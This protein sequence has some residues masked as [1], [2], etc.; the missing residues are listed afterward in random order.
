MIGVRR[1]AVATPPVLDGDGSAGRKERAAAVRFYQVPANRPK[2]FPAG[3][4]VYKSEE[5][6]EALTVLFHG[7][8]AY[9]E[10]R[11][12][13]VHPV[14]IEHYR[15][16]AA[17]EHRGALRK[18]GYYWLAAEWTNL[19][20]S[21]IDCNRSRRHPKLGDDADPEISGKAN[22]FPI[23]NEGQRATR[24][25]QESRERRLLLD[26]CRDRPDAHLIFQDDA[27]VLPRSAKGKTSIEVYGLN[28]PEL[29]GE[30]NDVLLRVKNQMDHATRALLAAKARPTAANRRFLANELSYLLYFGRGAQPY[31]GMVRQMSRAYLEKMAVKLRACFAGDV[32]KRRS[33]GETADAFVARHATVDPGRPALTENPLADLDAV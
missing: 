17:V 13:V 6:K 3:F 1:S 24:P 29:V 26:P 28:R 8:C 23:A 16:K 32:P 11:Y 19:L 25:K 10:A 27:L 18:P 31:A 5:I 15:P 4:K 2:A 21:C 33:A 22:W 9:C 12:D 30:R 20:P 7:K 14:D